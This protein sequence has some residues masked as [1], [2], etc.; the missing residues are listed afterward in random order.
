LLI[1]GVAAAV[2]IVVVGRKWNRAPVPEVV[3]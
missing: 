1:N 2:V 3:P